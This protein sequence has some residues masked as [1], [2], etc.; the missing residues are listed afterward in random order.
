[1]ARGA[2][3]VARGPWR[4]AR[5]AW[6]AAR[7]IDIGL[8]A[9]TRLGSARTCRRHAHREKRRLRGNNMSVTIPEQS[10]EIPIC[11][12]NNPDDGVTYCAN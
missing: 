3:R 7:D 5:G 2:W 6:R 11:S 10:T 4:V 12:K 1:V 9:G 8:T